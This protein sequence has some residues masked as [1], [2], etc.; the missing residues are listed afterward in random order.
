MF[1]HKFS[2]AKPLLEDIIANGVT[3]S[4]LKYALVANYQDNFNAAK[5]IIQNLFLQFKCL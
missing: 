1:Q 3:A 5:R 2:D 4:G